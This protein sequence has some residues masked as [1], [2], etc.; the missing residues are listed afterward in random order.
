MRTIVILILCVFATGCNSLRTR[1]VDESWPASI[2][3]CVSEGHLMVGM[4][5]EQAL[6]SWGRP[7]HVTQT[8]DQTGVYENWQYQFTYNNIGTLVYF[9]NGKIIAIQE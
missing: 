8:V 1:T 2:K 3:K 9:K 4:T 5:K 6:A 7:S